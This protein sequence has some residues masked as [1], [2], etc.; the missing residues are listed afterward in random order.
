M[1]YKNIINTIEI[2][3]EVMNKKVVNGS[4]ALDCTVG[5]GNDTFLLAKL[6][7]DKGKVYGFDI[8]D[9]AINNTFD[10]LK[11][12]SLDNRVKLIGDSHEYIDKYVNEGVDFI[13]YNLGYLPKGDK[14]IKTNGKSTVISLKKSLD[15]L[16]KNGIL[17]LTVYVGHDGGLE[18]KE[19]IERYF[20]TLN[21]KEYNVLK[22][23]FINQI[24]NP[25]ILYIVEKNFK[26]SDKWIARSNSCN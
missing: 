9:L 2:A 21:Q 22:F 1:S 15:I 19:S 5:N 11:Q 24:N 7:G 13:V 17:A 10:L 16:N 20:K 18:E 6:V 25:P 8:Q 3:K 4:I 26:L 23:D 14:S 12:N